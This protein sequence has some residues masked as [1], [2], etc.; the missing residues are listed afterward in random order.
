MK[1]GDNNLASCYQ[2]AVHDADD[3]KL[4]QI[5]IYDKL[6]DLVGRDGN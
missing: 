3:L 4:L 6:M 2:Y 1:S 5:K